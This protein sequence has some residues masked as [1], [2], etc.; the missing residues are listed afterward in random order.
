MAITV[1]NEILSNSENTDVRTLCKVLPMLEITIDNEML[2]KDLS[3]LCNRILEV[4][5]LLKHFNSDILQ[6]EAIKY[7]YNAMQLKIQYDRQYNKIQNHNTLK[8]NTR[9]YNGS[10]MELINELID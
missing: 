8:V 3:I 9:Q 6:Y 2:I 1:T 5:F 7:S 10:V 4:G